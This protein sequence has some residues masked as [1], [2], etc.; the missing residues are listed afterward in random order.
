MSH[1]FLRGETIQVVVSSNSVLPHKLSNFLDETDNVAMETTETMPPNTEHGTTMDCDQ[2]TPDDPNVM[3][4]ESERITFTVHKELLASVSPELSSHVFNDMMEGRQG[5]LVLEDV[6][7]DTV[8][9]FL[10]WAYTKKYKTPILTDKDTA[11]RKGET[12]AALVPHC[13]MYCFADRFNVVHLKRL[14]FQSIREILRSRSTIADVHFNRLDD[15]NQPDDSKKQDESKK[16]LEEMN[17]SVILGTDICFENLPC[18]DPTRLT[19]NIERGQEGTGERSEDLLGLLISFIAWDLHTLR[20]HK[21]FSPLLREHPDIAEALIYAAR[22]SPAPAWAAVKST[23]ARLS[24]SSVRTNRNK[25]LVKL[26]GQCIQCGHTGIPAIV[27]KLCDGV[28]AM[29]ECSDRLRKASSS[30]PFIKHVC[31]QC[32]G[33]KTYYTLGAID[34][35]CRI[36][37]AY[38][39]NAAGSGMGSGLR[40]P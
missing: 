21:L 38:M 1:S 24:I 22:P 16:D 7:S 29:D 39:G 19:E 34:V 33:S 20:H 30:V 3:T 15:P 18:S 25:L 26:I 14:T 13:R 37:L 28:D 5:I 32:Q 10:G 36:C 31:N 8:E 27:C 23:L 35:K 40:R 6:G 9:H 12:P 17:N 2:T 4:P 11:Y